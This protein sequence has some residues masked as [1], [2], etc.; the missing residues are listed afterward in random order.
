MPE[1][2]LPVGVL[3]VSALALAPAAPVA[4]QDVTT[5]SSHPAATEP[6]P[7]A[8]ERVTFEE[9]VARALERQPTVAQ[10][11]EAVR[12]SEAL[13][14]DARTVFQPLVM[15]FVG[16][17]IIDSARGFG[18][19]IVVPRKQTAFS[20]TISF[21]LLDV[22]R[23]AATS[24]A[25]DQVEIARL[26]ANDVRRQVAVTAAQAYLLVLA[27][28]HQREI[29]LRN[30]ETAET[31]AD[32]ARTRLEA[33]LGS[34][35]NFVRATQELATAE[36]LVQAAE[37]AVHQ[38]R[39]ALGVAIFADGP[40][41]ATGDPEIAVPA[42]PSQDQAR[43]EQRS[44]LRVFAAQAAAAD[45][46]LSDNWK[47]WLPT[48]TASFTPQYVTPAGLFEQARTWRALFQLEIPVFDGSLGAGRKIALA[49][50]ETARLQLLSARA[51]ARAEVRAAREAV[52]RNEQIAASA[53]EAATN[54][55]EALRITDI[56]YR[57][58]ATTNAEVVQAQQTTRRVESQ[59]ALAQDRLLLARLEL[60]VALGEFP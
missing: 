19:S 40:V 16:E 30:R 50:R 49:D 28:L 31:L 59:A 54:A 56:A 6:S 32:Y 9:A 57:A 4:A 35:L 8:L 23:W 60:L 33:G 1:R 25:A 27:A 51:E 34:R 41:D 26:S 52:Q 43:I 13:L 14:D 42:P 21:P 45:R 12:R 36:G 58:G 11:L 22:S 46:V 20:A 38:A 7:A 10:A 3:V 53:R 18:D 47:S 2:L 24:H 15:G 29:A 5:T 17:T 44:D 48:A 39:E 55:A 37:L